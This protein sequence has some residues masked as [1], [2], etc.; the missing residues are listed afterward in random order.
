MCQEFSHFSSF[1]HHFV[2]AKLATSSIRV[3]VWSMFKLIL[4]SSPSRYYRL[5][6]RSRYKRSLIVIQTRKLFELRTSKWIQM[7]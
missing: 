5:L 1:S 4:V 2:L 3:D 7:N 6:K